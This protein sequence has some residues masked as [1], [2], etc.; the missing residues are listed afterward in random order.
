MGDLSIK[1]TSALFKRY[2]ARPITSL[3]CVVLLW[4]MQG[5]KGK[6]SEHAAAPE[7]K[8]S[9]TTK[10]KIKDLNNEAIDLSQHHGKTIFINFWATWCGPCIKEMPSI[11]RA[12]NMLKDRDIEFVV[13]S[14]ESI[15]Q[16]QSFATKRKLDLRY[17][18]LQNLEELNIPALPTTYIINPTGELVFSETGY[19]EWDEAANIELLTKIID[20]HE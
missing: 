1:Y 12:K 16:I 9:I 13:A 3:V 15:E 7:T 4:G 20:G 14:N 5:C 19:R 18:Q 17:V 2:G 6:T 11:E 8:E 10:I